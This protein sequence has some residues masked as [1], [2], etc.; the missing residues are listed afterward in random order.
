MKPLMYIAA[1]AVATVMAVPSSALAQRPDTWVTM[2]T[3]IALM[4]ADDVSASDLN[5]DTVS[6]AVTLHGKV[7]TDAQKASAERITKGIE[8]V[9]SVQN[10]LQVVPAASRKATEA[11]DDDI[12]TR[13]EAAFKANRVVDES[14]IE[15]SSVNKGVVLLSGTADTVE[16]HLAA[17][18]TARGVAGV[19]RVAT[20]VEVSARQ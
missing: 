10:L 12:E 8:G 11:T 1:A 17:I 20:Q 14:G 7:E 5:V 2:K 19:R 3:K 15:V 9:K 18:E 13:V 4:T 16:A 6:G